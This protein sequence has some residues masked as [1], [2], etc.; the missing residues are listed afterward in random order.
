MRSWYMNVLAQANNLEKAGVTACNF[1][2]CEAHREV[3]TTSLKN[4]TKRGETGTL[5]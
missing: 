1:V 3:I 5:G 2:E 4:A